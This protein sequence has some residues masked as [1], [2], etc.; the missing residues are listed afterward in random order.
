MYAIIGSSNIDASRSNEAI[1]LVKSMLD[2][3]S[4]APGFVSAVF[5]RSPDGT[6]GRS[7]IVFESEEAAKA[8]AE[9]ARSMI[10]ADSPTEIVSLEIY[11][12]VD[13]R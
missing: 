8:V 4:H 2:N 6:T 11:E 3:I 5:T 13:S 9:N 1:Q 10:L 7:M 12:V